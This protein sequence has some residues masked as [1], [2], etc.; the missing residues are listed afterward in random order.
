MP[1]VSSG[2]GRWRRGAGADLQQQAAVQS[3]SRLQCPWT[4]TPI[5]SRRSA[6]CALCPARPRRARAAHQF[7]EAESAS[8]KQV[9]NGKIAWRP[10]SSFGMQRAAA[11]SSTRAHQCEAARRQLSS[12]QCYPCCSASCLPNH[13]R[14]STEHAMN[15][16]LG[17]AAFRFIGSF[18]KHTEHREPAS[19]VANNGL[20][21]DR[22]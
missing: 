6:S 12:P 9:I 11:A 22:R 8:E 4:D 5:G 18:S 1:A 13:S 19:T 3:K 16:S 14:A 17:L 20:P 10:V 2:V 15:T 7:H 21:V